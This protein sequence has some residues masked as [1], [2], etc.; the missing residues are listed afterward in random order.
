MQCLRVLV[1]S[2]VVRT[3]DY[4]FKDRALN[5]S[6]MYIHM[7]L[8]FNHHNCYLYM[9]VRMSYVLYT[10]MLISKA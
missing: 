2:S 7:Y 6:Y 4:D 5:P 3:V 9:Y 10:G 8:V 1:R